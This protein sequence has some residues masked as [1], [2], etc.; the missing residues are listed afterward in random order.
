MMRYLVMLMFFGAGAAFAQ[1]TVRTG[2]DVLAASNFDRLDGKTVGLVVNHTA[3]V[4]DEHLIN[5]VHAA[6][7]VRVGAIFGPEHGLRG[8]AEDGEAVSDGKDLLTGAP[9]YSL[10]GATRKPTSTMLAGLDVLI[11]D[12]QDVG[13][14]FYTFISTMGLSMQAAA[15]AGIPF[16]VL[17]RPNPL[18]GAYVSGFVLES[19]QES[20]VGQYAIPIA[21]GLT[22]G[23][24]AMM[25]QGEGLMPGLESLAL[26]VVSMEGWDR[27]M[28]WPDTGRPWVATSPNIPRFDNAL[29]YPGTCFFEATS[30]SE[31]R[32]TL[33]PFLQVGSIEV[34]GARIA[35]ELNNRSLPGVRFEGVEFTPAP[36]SSMD[37]APK[38][39]GQTIRGLGITVTDRQNYQPVEVGIHILHAYYHASPDSD[40]FLTRPEWLARLS[41]TSRL[42]EML[43]S[44]TPEAIIA[45]W[46]DDTA[47]FTQRSEHYYLYD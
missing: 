5:L 8:T 36:L 16:I 44:I 1:E 47:R 21:H 27:S 25:I 12:I 26:E 17:D 23:E 18:S 24:L 41:G 31:G 33:T 32:G 14:R 39:N 2:A 7:N 38:L 35:E 29:V 15:E 11:F 10:Y 22:V 37:T 40:Q 9:V 13:A 20:F 3:L 28:Q 34:D 46:E 19:D 43:S 4:G 45:S 42:L 6:P 30:A